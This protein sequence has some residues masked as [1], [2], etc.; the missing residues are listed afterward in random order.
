MSLPRAGSE[1]A[2]GARRS[3]L[4]D[5]I[6]GITVS[7]FLLILL[8]GALR[9]FGGP[10]VDS[11]EDP[12]V[13]FS[14]TKPLFQLHEGVVST[15]PGRIKYFNRVSFQSPKPANTFRIFCF[16]GSTTYGRPFDGRTSFSR[17]LQDLLNASEPEAVFEVINAGGISYASYR[18]VPLIK[19]ALQYQPDLVIIYTG[20]N[21]F[22]ERRTYAGLFS[23][24]AGLITIR[25]VLENLYIYQALKRVIEPLL[26][27]GPTDAG[28][29][30]GRRGTTMDGSGGSNRSASSTGKSILKDD[31]TAILDRSA[32]LDR[33][34]RDEK[35]ARGVIQH[36]ARNIETMIY[37]CKR[38]GIPVIMVEP[39]SNLKD[40][41]PFKSEHRKD[42][43]S[44]EKSELDG[45]IEQAAKLVRQGR[46]EES[47]GGLDEAIKKDP[48][49]AAAYF[50]RGKAM[51]GMGRYAQ[52]RNDFVKARDLDVC[53][54]RCITQL[55]EKIRHISEKEHVPLIRFQ[56][57]LVKANNGKD[58]ASDLPGN[59]SFLDHVH[60]TVEGHQLLA[61]LIMDEMIRTRLVRPKRVLSREEK[62]SIYVTGMKGLDPE[63]FV[64]K[65]L[66]LAKV[67]R[68]AG[69]KDEARQVLMKTKEKLSDNPE[70]HKMLGSFLLEDGRHGQAIEE[71]RKAVQLSAGDPVLRFSLANAYY[72]AG[73]QSKSQ[74]IYEK[75]LA[76]SGPMPDACANLAMIHLEAGRIDRSLAVLEKGL[77]ATPDAESLFGPYALAL[78]IS[79][80]PSK[81]VAWMVRAVEADPGDAGHLYNLAGMYALSGKPQDALR[82]LNEAVDKG[83]ADADK[84]VRDSVF[85]SIRELPEFSRIVNRIR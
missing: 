16:G 36:F 76:E 45:K 77:A 82:T 83:Y 73:L 19:E 9:I 23:Q 62:D 48:L 69:K 34:H 43:T 10:S 85:A 59:E 38:A 31:V 75:L 72:K 33:Y 78:A 26:P 64:T 58:A 49:Y 27:A 20:H 60:P 81:A 15:V 61:E 41:S 29:E 32:G 30:R 53:P 66:N 80:N 67:L 28:N 8:E 25:S 47:L 13:G 44:S 22:L 35:F 52:A 56:H 70:V 40:F 5:A 21:E 7:L 1:T 65:D 6:L 55:E 54:L 46:Y 68:W 17:W 50:R 11:S 37:V 42:L 74:E 63:F 24:G 71:Y 18:I 2:G 3:T 39:A 4:K 12:Y 14:R 79:G 51:L 84:M 57:A